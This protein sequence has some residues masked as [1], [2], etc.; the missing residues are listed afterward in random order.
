MSHFFAGFEKAAEHV[1]DYSK[2]ER[3]S[4]LPMWKQKMIEAGKTPAT[5][6]KLRTLLPHFPK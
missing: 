4:K 3:S 5:A 1:I 6:K 2:L